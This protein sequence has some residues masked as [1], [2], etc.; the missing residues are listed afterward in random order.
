MAYMDKKPNAYSDLVVL[1]EGKDRLE[2]SWHKL[3]DNINMGL[4]KLD[5]RVWN[6]FSWLRYEP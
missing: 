5:V 1:P 3:G 2:K 6:G 4:I